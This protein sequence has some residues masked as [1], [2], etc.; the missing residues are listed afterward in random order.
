MPA[1]TKKETPPD[2]AAV[3]A[4]ALK[5]AGFAVA[6]VRLSPGVHDDVLTVTLA[7]GK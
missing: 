7:K 6:S 3:C 1:E 4:E 2:P 5:A